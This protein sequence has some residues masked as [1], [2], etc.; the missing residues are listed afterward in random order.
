MTLRRRWQDFPEDMRNEFLDRLGDN[1]R[2]LEHLITHLLDF[3]RMERGEFEMELRPHDLAGLVRRL[4]GNMVHELS[5]H[6]VRA[7]VPEGLVVMTDPYAFDRILGNL[8]SNAAKFSPPET[9]I[10]I[11]GRREG[12][13]VALSVRDHGPGIP[14]DARERIFELFYRRS[15]QARGTG[16]GLAVVR[17]LVKLHGGRVEARNAGPGAVFTVHLVAASGAG[18]DGAPEP[19]PARAGR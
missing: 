4:L 6:D 3:G 5:H 17:D 9:V 15:G 11:A 13:E 1:A 7:H 10:E 14:E 2:S 8:L 16:I 12:D 19:V 18:A